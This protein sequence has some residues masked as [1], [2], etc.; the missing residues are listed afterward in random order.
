M[1]DDRQRCLEAGM[2][3]YVSK[4]IKLGE[5]IAVLEKHLGAGVEA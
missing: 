5:L 4:P 1:A 2:D 3:G